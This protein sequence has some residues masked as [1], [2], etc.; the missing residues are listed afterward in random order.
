MTDKILT[1]KK[2]HVLTMCVNRPEKKNAF[3]ME[4]LTGLAEAYT[5]LSNNDNLRCGVVYA[6]GDVFT[7]GIDLPNVL[8]HVMEGDSSKLVGPGKCDP[9]RYY[10]LDNVC[11]KPVIVAVHGRCYTIGIELTL[12]ADMCVAASDTIFGQME[13]MRG[14]IPFG[15]ACI[16]MPKVFGWHNAMRYILTAE[17]FG[18]EEAKRFGMVQE[19]TEPGKQLEKAME[20]AEKI[21]DNAPLAVMA[22]LES[23]RRAE[24]E[25]VE[26]AIAFNLDEAFKL[27]KTEDAREGIMSLVEKR[28][29]EFKGK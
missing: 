5:E 21:A 1:E 9:F 19:I 2:G 15:G 12:A 3:D 11:K 28:K 24:Y 22:A 13:V 7:A 29:P 4:M 25:S 20:F 18:A 17:T 6:N 16:R 23:A 10:N 14:I 27:A 26:K 8:P